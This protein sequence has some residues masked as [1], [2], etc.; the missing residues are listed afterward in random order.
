LT[1]LI[2]IVVFSVFVMPIVFLLELRHDISSA[3]ANGAF[4][5]S[6]IIV[7]MIVFADKYYSLTTFAKSKSKVWTDT[8]TPTTGV[9]TSAVQIFSQDVVR[10]M[11]PD[12]QYEYYTKVIQKYS[13]LR[14]RLNCGSENSSHASI[15]AASGHGYAL[16]RSSHHDPLSPSSIRQQLGEEVE[17]G[18]I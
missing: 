10:S 6:A 3:I 14:L 2:V 17:E 4:G 9:S 7:L 18:E 12:E 15:S 16:P 13:D 5:V 11:T 1:A 8:Q